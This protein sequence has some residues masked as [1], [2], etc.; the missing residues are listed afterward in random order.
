MITMTR[1]MTDRS[2]HWAVRG[3]VVGLAVAATVSMSACGDNSDNPPEPTFTT[4]PVPSST[5]PA[6][7][8]DGTGLAQ[9][10]YVE[11]DRDRFTATD[12]DDPE[13]VLHD[14]VREAFSW[15]PAEDSNG[16]DAIL[17]SHT[18]WNNDY[19]RA[20]EVRLTT[21]VPM[22]SRD[23]QTWGDRDQRFD[24]TVTLTSEQHPAD[25]DSDFSRVVKVSLS[26]TG[27][28]R[29]DLNREIVTLMV[30]ARVHKA[31]VG[32]RIDSLDLTD[33]ILPEVQ[34]S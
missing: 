15:N 33:S 29:P 30:R 5:A 6:Q 21:L 11:L 3:T 25:T 13:S 7:V 28:S 14:G 34:T 32:W 22:S 9:G 16:W 18:A 8:G 17:R 26:T 19:L 4:V 20:Q 23:W 1:K 2:R 12:S 24:A 31:D 10:A 27:G